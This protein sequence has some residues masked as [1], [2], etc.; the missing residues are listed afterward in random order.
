MRRHRSG[1]EECLLPCP[2][3]SCLMM[4]GDVIV[5]GDRIVLVCC[6]GGGMRWCVAVVVEVGVCA[7][8]SPHGDA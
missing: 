2:L 8:L 3:T 4:W 1:M 6:H 5:D 7:V